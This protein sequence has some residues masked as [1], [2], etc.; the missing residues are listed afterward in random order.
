MTKLLFS[1]ERDI[2]DRWGK[3][4]FGATPL[5]PPGEADDPGFA[6]LCDHFQGASYRPACRSCLTTTTRR[7]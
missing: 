3:L 6:A 1:D 7:R 2:T 5:R 4:R